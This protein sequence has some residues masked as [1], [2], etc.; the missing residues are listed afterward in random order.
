MF[1][2]LPIQM[3]ISFK[4]SLTNTNSLRNNVLSTIWASLS[5]VRL[6]HMCFLDGS[7]IRFQDDWFRVS[8]YRIFFL[9]CSKLLP[10]YQ[11]SMGSLLSDVPQYCNKAR[12]Y[13]GSTGMCQLTR[14]PSRGTLACGCVTEGM[15]WSL[16]GIRRAIAATYFLMSLCIHIHTIYLK[17]GTQFPSFPIHTPLG[18]E[19]CSSNKNRVYSAV[20]SKA[21]EELHL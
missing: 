1:L 18:S 4:N 12:R 2:I 20:F 6:T 11:S 8:I 5:P 14:A 3:L 19:C 15:P 16:Q 9:K 21:V 10:A 7:R 17:M 13:Q